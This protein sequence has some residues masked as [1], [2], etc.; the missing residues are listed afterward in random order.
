MQIPGFREHRSYRE[1]LV[2]SGQA[3]SFSRS[4]ISSIVIVFR[5]THHQKS[6][7]SKDSDQL[8]LLKNYSSEILEHRT[9]LKLWLVKLLNPDPSVTLRRLKIRTFLLVCGFGLKPSQLLK[10]ILNANIIFRPNTSKLY[11]L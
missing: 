10:S 11:K 4:Q 8:K 2:S 1:E 9:H 5:K 3:Y 6:N 7:E